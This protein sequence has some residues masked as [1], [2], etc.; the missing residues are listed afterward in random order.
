MEGEEERLGGDG[1]EWK[2]RKRSRVADTPSLLEKGKNEL[3]H[4]LSFGVTCTDPIT[5]SLAP[6]P[7]P[8][9]MKHVD[10][11]TGGHLERNPG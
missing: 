3:S 1:E 11:R 5:F 10:P 2:E 6:I 7:P 9:Y 8:N 4:S